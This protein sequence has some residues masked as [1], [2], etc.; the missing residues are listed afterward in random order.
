MSR[1]ESYCIV[2]KVITCWGDVCI[3]NCERVYDYMITLFFGSSLPFCLFDCFVCGSSTFAMII[4]LLMVADA[5]G[6][7]GQ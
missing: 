3:I 6:T 7:R 5:R 4:N 2:W 1:V